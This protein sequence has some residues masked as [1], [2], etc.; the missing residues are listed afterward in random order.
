MAQPL[1]VNLLLLVPLISYYF[2]RKRPISTTA[3][4]LLT[5]GL[6][7]IG[8]G[9]VEAAV[10]VY[11][12]AVLAMSAGYG[13]TVSD[14]A[15][16][17]LAINAATID[18]PPVLS[19]SLLVL[20]MCRE[21]ATMLMLVTLSILAVPRAR[22]RWPIF[23]WV[24]AIW[25]LTYYATLK[26]TIAWPARLTDLDVLF[27]I[28]VPWISQVWFPVLVSALSVAAVL[29]GRKRIPRVRRHEDHLQRLF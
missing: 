29:L 7:A 5:C 1:W 16:F 24:F 15:R 14:V 10:V 8:F 18:P 9:V 20:E 22:D 6:F 19:K 2:W 4:Q 13:A 11:L 12:R 17:S 28:P 25:D 26:A 21:A 3:R 27:L 23:L